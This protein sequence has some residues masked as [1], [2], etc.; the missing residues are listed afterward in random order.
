MIKTVRINFIQFVRSLGAMASS[1]SSAMD[2]GSNE[3]SLSNSSN[4]AS[5]TEE[6]GEKA[7]SPHKANA[8]QAGRKVLH[9]PDMKE[10]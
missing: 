6:E 9:P 5:T 1:N 3:A 7:A 4:T 10:V 2:F 8:V